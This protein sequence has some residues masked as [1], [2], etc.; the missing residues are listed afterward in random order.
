V[1]V[2]GHPR[3]IVSRAIEHSNLVVAEQVA[4]EVANLTANCRERVAL[5]RRHTRMG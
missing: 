3:A 4:R 5:G 1:T 2:Q